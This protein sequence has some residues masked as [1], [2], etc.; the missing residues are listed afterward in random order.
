MPILKAHCYENDKIL[1]LFLQIEKLKANHL[2]STSK[3]I[4]R[5]PALLRKI[6]NTSYVSHVDPV[7]N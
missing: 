6:I 1:F 3:G 5:K 2:P 7:L 4:L